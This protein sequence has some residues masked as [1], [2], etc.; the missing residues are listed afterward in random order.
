MCVSVCPR[1]RVWRV[2]EARPIKGTA[3]RVKVCDVCCLLRN[4]LHT[5]APTIDC[6]VPRMCMRM[7]V[8]V[9]V[10]AC[11]CA[12]NSPLIAAPKQA[13]DMHIPPHHVSC[14]LAHKTIHNLQRTCIHT[15]IHAHMLH[16]H[17]ACLV[18][19]RMITCRM[20]TDDQ[21]QDD[22]LQDDHLQDDPAAG[23]A[24]AAA[25]A[26]S[27]KDRAEKRMIVHILCFLLTG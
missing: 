25:L 20:I 6:R 5:C 27:E 8:F 9:S 12:A 7:Y 26:S 14:S 16:N 3:P 19:C 13:A 21:L 18:T 1:M 22:H 10:F 24:A 15:I 4:V 23:A 2:L 11:V 17:C